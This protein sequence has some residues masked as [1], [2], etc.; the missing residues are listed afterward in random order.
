MKGRSI[1]TL[2]WEG[3][4]DTYKKPVSTRQK[5]C[6]KIQALFISASCLIYSRTAYTIPAP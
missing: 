3:Q 4:T 5:V 2:L 6:A 1:G